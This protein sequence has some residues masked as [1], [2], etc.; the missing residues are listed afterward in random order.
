LE[1]FVGLIDSNLT[2]P[3]PTVSKFNLPFKMLP[4]LVQPNLKQNPYIESIRG[5][6]W[7]KISLTLVMTLK[8]SLTQFE[9]AEAIKWRQK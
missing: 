7:I 8:K 2:K 6:K 5:K 3:H 4:S 9:M 1:I